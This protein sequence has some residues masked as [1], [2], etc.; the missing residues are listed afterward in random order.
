[1][2]KLI[3]FVFIIHFFLF[4]TNAQTT[5]NHPSDVDWLYIEN[6][7]IRVIYPKNTEEQAKRIADV[8]NHIKFHNT[9]SV[10]SKS[11]KI[12]LILQTQ[13]VSS[14]GFV[15][16]AP[17][18]S[19]FF[20]TP[21]QNFSS[22]GSTDWLDLLAI[23]EY[24]HVLQYSNLDR[25][26][27]KFLHII[28]GD[29][30]WGGSISFKIPSWYLEGDAVLSESLLTENGRGRNPFFFKEQRAL[31]LNNIE[32]SYMKANNGSYKDIVPNRYPLGF[33]MV[34][35]LR[36]N[37]NFTIGAEVL[38]RSGATISPFWTFSQA[39]KSLTGLTTANLY[40]QSHA[41]IQKRWKQEISDK[42]LTTSKSISS[43]NK[44]IV[45]NYTFP[46]YDN[47]NGI[48][49]IKDSYKT[50][51]EIVYLKNGQESKITS[52]GITPQE[53]ISYKNNMLLWTELELDIRRANKNYSNI[54]VFDIEKNS[55]KQITKKGKFFSPDLSNNGEKIITVNSNNTLQHKLVILDSKSGEVIAS[56]ENP[57]ND[58]I[59]Y[60][61]WNNNDNEII[62]LAKRNSK[63]AFFKY[64]LASKLTLR[65]TEWTS[66]TIGHFQLKGNAAYYTASFDGIDNIFKTNLKKPNKT[67]QIS[68]VKTGAFTPTIS[69]NGKNIIFSE[70]T[71]KGYVLKEMANK[72]V[73]KIQIVE[74]TEQFLHQIITSTKEQPILS[75]INKQNYTKK[76][77]KGFFKGFKLHSWGIDMYNSSAE[78]QVYYLSMNNLLN[79]LSVNYNLIHNRNEATFESKGSIR[80]GKYFIVANGVFSNSERNFSY[81]N[82]ARKGAIAN[83]NENKLSLGI[84]IPLSAVKGNYARSF[85]F[86]SYYN[87]H[88]TYNYFDSP[89]KTVNFG[90]VSSTISFSNYRRTALQNLA[91]KYGQYLEFNINN[92]TEKG[93]A[94]NYNIIAALFLPGLSDNHSLSL[95]A[96]WNKQPVTTSYRF[97]D[98]FNY[99]R[100]YNGFFN[101]EG[102]TLRANYQLPLYYPDFGFWN[103]IYFK[104]IRATLFY[105]KSILASF[106]ATE[107]EEL[108]D[109]NIEQNSYG[110]EIML[111]NTLFNKYAFSFGL[112]NSF[113]ENT[114]TKY[115][116]NSYVPEIILSIG[117]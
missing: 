33:V 67:V 37:S 70:F 100:G 63:I 12:D 28:N 53:Y 1:M 44:K 57:K 5:G 50:T 77:Y 21:P 7:N 110:F 52:I 3:S 83:F 32:Y 95:N 75:K 103:L 97:T 18:R 46:Y 105:D 81:I 55:K 114:D 85:N 2:K 16:V 73:S 112:R 108:V 4:H 69:N 61:K 62:Y 43:E 30:G 47:N 51:S 96:F 104:R 40:K 84:S 23:H 31:L 49:C 9:E 48:Y 109:L 116:T 19:E 82:N 87:H 74:P 64:S 29:I 8:I 59:S 65:I 92:S 58:F 66:H 60:P 27:T 115:N 76:K 80:Y 10:G 106:G 79:D 89:G 102:T 11:K 54:I 14:N 22:L 34:N 6:E 25:G 38:S 41:D 15:T 72:D 86:S 36:N 13:Q 78:S 90:S 94:E 91:P 26:F 71:P 117:L 88:N 113:L 20:G 24:R 101:K 99:A 35:Y 42:S 111:D 56:I 39:L 45:T 98:R 107:E 17:F 93:F 68:S